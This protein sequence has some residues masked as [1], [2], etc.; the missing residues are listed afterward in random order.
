MDFLKNFLQKS[1]R[2]STKPKNPK[3][4]AIFTV[5]VNDYSLKV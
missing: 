4:H 3:L 2:I 5:N 1:D